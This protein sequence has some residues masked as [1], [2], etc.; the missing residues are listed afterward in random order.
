LKS[1]FQG[2]EGRGIEFNLEKVKSNLNLSDLG[3]SDII[4]VHAVA[5]AHQN[6]QVIIHIEECIPVNVF[7][8]E[9]AT[10]LHY[11]SRSGRYPVVE[12]LLEKGVNVNSVDEEGNTPLDIVQQC[13]HMTKYDKP[14][15]EQYIKYLQQTEQIL[16]HY[17]GKV[18]Q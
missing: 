13:Q 2:N 10:P 12:F 7:Y 15:D 17:G 1:V 6:R 8:N 5:T 14:I 3:E 16:L 11:Y 9:G 4:R 18:Q